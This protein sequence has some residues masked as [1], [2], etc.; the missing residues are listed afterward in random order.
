MT[1]LIITLFGLIGL[2]VGATLFEWRHIYFILGFVIVLIFIAFYD[3]FQTRHTIL[4]NF[5]VLGHFRYILEFIRPEIQQYFIASNQNERPF[6]RETRNLVYQRAK[7]IRD[8]IPFGTQHDIDEPGYE[9]IRHSLNPTHI[10][11]SETRIWIGD[12][13]C[14]QPYH[15][16]RLNVSAMSFG[17][18][19]K[20]AILALNKGAKLG[21]FAHNTGEGGLSPYHLEG[22]GDI[23]WQIG[24]AYFGCRTHDGQFD[25]VLFREKAQHPHVKMIE[26]K[27]SQGAKPSH[28]GVL[29]AAKIS[30]E[31][32]LIR[33]IHDRSKDCISPPTHSTF[34]DPKGLLNFIAQLRELSGGKPVG[35]KLAIGIR[36]EFLSICKAMLAYHILP[37]FITVDGAEGGTGAAPVE[38]SNRLAEPIN[39]ALLFVHYALKGVN[40][41]DPIRILASGKISTGFDMIAKMA[42]GADLCYS[43]RAM[44]FS[45]GCIQALQCNTNACPTGI[46]TQN[47]RLVRGLVVNDKYKR[48][49][50][51]HQGTL[52]SMLELAGAMGVKHL[53]DLTPAYL[54]H[55]INFAASKSYAELYERIKTGDLLKNTVPHSFARDWALASA[56]TF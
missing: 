43:A 1:R 22:G 7:G 50:N 55:R 45:L 14:T 20:N 11:P 2:F 19:S 36:S 15:A 16:S 51:F 37:D 13:E 29:P 26:I 30:E 3:F 32:A 28:G 34:S 10:D 12:K 40:L 6:S 23:I 35:F 41:R 21:N 33:G 27:L 46:T 4:R 42:L 25:P 48:G 54:N 24:T 38:F 39:E 56:D 47:P 9:S 8:T 5:P 17:A 18:I 31:I 53:D 49:A 52:K 44:L